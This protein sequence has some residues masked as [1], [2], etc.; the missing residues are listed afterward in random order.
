MSI[1]FDNSANILIFDRERH[2]RES[3]RNYLLA[4]GY[5]HIHVVASIQS[6]LVILRQQHFRLILLGV[7]PPI[8]AMQRLAIV[9]RRRQA[10]AK[11]FLLIDGRDQP[12]FVDMPEA[13]ILRDYMYANL[14]ELI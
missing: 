5:K 2:L 13:V 6:A 8:L 10:A 3:L 11:I 12:C 14:L 4:E 9:A 1:V 7:S